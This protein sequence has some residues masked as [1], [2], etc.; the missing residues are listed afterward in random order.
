M[1]PS[2]PNQQTSGDIVSGDT[3]VFLESGRNMTMPNRSGCCGA[4]VDVPPK[5]W[6][7]LCVRCNGKLTHDFQP[8]P[9][10]HQPGHNERCRLRPAESSEPDS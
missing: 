4:D 5:P 9:G 3:I 1:K 10:Q 2:N 7:P 8:Y 6:F